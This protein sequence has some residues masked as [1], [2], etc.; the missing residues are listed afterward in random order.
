[1]LL[2]DNLAI[3]FALLALT[4]F[5]RSREEGS[6]G[7]FALGCL[8]VALALLTRQAFVWLLPVGLWCAPRRVPGAALLAL[9]FAPLG[10]LIVA[11]GGLVP[12]GS[13]PTSCGLCPGAGDNLLGRS[14]GFTF[15]VFAIYAVLV[16]GPSVW[17]QLRPLLAPAGVA[18]ALLVAVGLLIAFPLDFVP[19]GPGVPGDAGY[20]W[21]ASE[22]LPGLFW[23]LVPLGTVSA[24]ALGRR[25]GPRSLAV[26]F[27]AS[28]LLSVLPVRLVY[29]KYFDPFALLAVALFARPPDFR[30]RW[31]YLGVAVVCA[32]SVAYAL[33]F[34][35]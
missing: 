4:L 23:L 31:D 2:T 19:P 16:L 11:W 17:R 7:L 35:G 5:L 27:G 1:V 26:V 25:A 3:L 8:C 18:V 28:F 22:K 6:M 9:A 29:Q 21:R 20:L 14:L 34:A 30:V 24:Y 12:K 13:D 33:S 10:A 15:A 32:A